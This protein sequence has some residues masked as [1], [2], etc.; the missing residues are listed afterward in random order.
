[1]KFAPASRRTGKHPP[2]RILPLPPVPSLTLSSA[3]LSRP[4]ASR[5][6][7]PS[8]P[9]GSHRRTMAPTPRAGARTPTLR[10]G[11]QR[12]RRA[13]REVR[14]AQDGPGR[15]VRRQQRRQPRRRPQDIAR[16]GQVADAPGVQPRIPTRFRPPAI[17]LQERQTRRREFVGWRGRGLVGVRFVRPRLGRE[18]GVLGPGGRVR[19]RLRVHRSVR[20][21]D[22]RM[23]SV[24]KN[25]NQHR[26]RWRTR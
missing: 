14:G 12:P 22:T 19:G 11:D 21:M 7:T 26:K 8:T 24:S 1:M 16:P 15:S 17:L 20:K 3:L 4:C 18:V 13:A 2:A 10:V 5:R 25:L 6:C 9:P 23:D